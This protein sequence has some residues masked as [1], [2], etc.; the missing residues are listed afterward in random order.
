MKKINCSEKEII[1]F[2]KADSPKKRIKLMKKFNLS[3][4]SIIT[5]RSQ[6]KYGFPELAEKHY[7]S[8]LLK[9]IKY[10]KNSFAIDYY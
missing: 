7:K 8:G 6:F 3:S 9:R 5:L 2:L 1:E 4:D 10:Q